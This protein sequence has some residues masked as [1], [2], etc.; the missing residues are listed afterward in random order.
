MEEVIGA[1]N[2]KQCNG[3]DSDLAD[4]SDNKR[5]GSLFE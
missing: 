3:S 2:Q 4:S 1:E 5:P